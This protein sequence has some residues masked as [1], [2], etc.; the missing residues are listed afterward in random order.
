MNSTSTLF[1]HLLTLP[2]T[3]FHHLTTRFTYVQVPHIKLKAEHQALVLFHIVKIGLAYWEGWR[4]G[5][6]DEK[7]GK[8]VIEGRGNK[9]QEGGERKGRSR[10]GR[11]R[12]RERKG[13]GRRVVGKG[14]YTVVF[15]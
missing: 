13:Y 15:M 8:D 9:G 10:D 12:N 2:T 3:L 5:R 6:R 4:D 7:R 1:S 11:E 14:K